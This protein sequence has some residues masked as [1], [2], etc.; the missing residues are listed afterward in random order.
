MLESLLTVWSHH[1]QGA[2]FVV[3][4]A[5]DE[6][7]SNR[8]RSLQVASCSHVAIRS[9]SRPEIAS[10]SFT[11]H[12]CRLWEIHRGFLAESE[13]LSDASSPRL[14][15]L[16][17]CRKFGI[18]YASAQCAGCQGTLIVRGLGFHMV[19]FR[20]YKS[21]QPYYVSLRVCSGR[22]QT[23]PFS[24]S[25]RPA[26]ISTSPRRS[27]PRRLQQWQGSL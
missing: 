1:S 21:S 5:V 13:G 17:S 3:D 26:E 8:F 20:V 27:H 2:V 22:Q 25:E 19:M 24:L 14:W 10:S 15:S 12:L 16:Q 7:I 6:V 23:R 18:S 9:Y 11:I 4:H